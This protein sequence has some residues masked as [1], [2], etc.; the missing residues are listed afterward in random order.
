MPVIEAVPLWAD[1]DTDMA[2]A[3]TATIAARTDIDS[4][5]MPFEESASGCRLARGRGG[6]AAERH[7]RRRGSLRVGAGELG[8]VGVQRA[9]VLAAGRLHLQRHRRS[10]LR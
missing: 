5:R 3:S 6:G 10:L 1:A 7:R 8:A 9:G 2:A 4:T